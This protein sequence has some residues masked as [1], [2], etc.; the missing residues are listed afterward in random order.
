MNS[1]FRFSQTF[2]QGLVLISLFAIPQVSLFGQ[3]NAIRRAA[4]ESQSEAIRL[5]KVWDAENIRGSISLFIDASKKWEKLGDFKRSSFCLIESAK[6]Y[7]RVSED[8]KAE[9]ALYQALRLSR[10]INDLDGRAIELALLARI[11]QKRGI[12]KETHS[13]IAK[14]IRLGETASPKTRAYIFFIAGEYEIQNSNTTSA[15]NHLEK[16]KSLLSDTS[17]ANLEAEILRQLAAFRYANGEIVRGLT[18]L[19]RA[20]EIWEGSGNKRGIALAHNAFGFVYVISN[21]KQKAVESYKKARALFPE[22]VDL[23]EQ[24][25][26]MKGLGAVYISLGRPD[27]AKAYIS[28]SLKLSTENKNKVGRSQALNALVLA[29]YLEGNLD[30]AKSLGAE[31]KAFSRNTGNTFG[32]AF[33]DEILGKIEADEGN[34]DAAIKRFR[35]VQA[36]YDRSRSTIT[37]PLNELGKAYEAKGDFDL[38]QK[39]YKTALKKNRRYRDVVNLSENLYRL[40]H[41]NDK[42]GN[43]DPAIKYS[44]EAVAETESIYYDLDNSGLRTSFLSSVYDRYDLYISLLMKIHKRIPNK[45]YDLK[46]L[47]VS[48]RARA[49]L[50]LENLRLTESDFLADGDPKLIKLRR[51][52]LVLLNV[53]KTQLTN[54]VGNNESK[55]SAD[56]LLGEIKRLEAKFDDTNAVLRRD[57]P[58]YSELKNPTEFDI[59]RFQKDVLDEDSVLLEFSFGSEESYLWLIGKDKV[60]TFVLPEREI[61]EKELD[62]LLK[63]LTT[64]RNLYDDTIE[65]SQRRIK[66][67]EKEFEIRSAKLS[68]K[69]FGQ[70]ASKIKNKRLIIVPDGKLR[71]FPIVALPFPKSAENSRENP[72]F[73]ETNEIIYEPSAAMLQLIKTRQNTVITPEKDLLVVSDPVFTRDDER[74]PPAIRNVRYRSGAFRKRKFD[75]NLESLNARS[76]LERLPG[77]DEEANRIFQA[78]TKKH[79]RQLSGFS[80][81]RKNLLEEN[82]S[83]YKILHFATHGLLN[84][85]NPELSGILLSFY[86]E[87]ANK[88]D[89]FIRLQDIY[90]FHLSS[91]LVVLSACDTAVGKEVKGEGLMSLTNG[92]LQVGAKAVIS[93]RWKVDDNA[94]LQLMDNFYEFMANERLTPSQALSKAQIKMFRKSNYK[95]PFYWAAFSIHGDFQKRIDIRAPFAYRKYFLLLGI[96]LVLWGVIAGTRYFNRH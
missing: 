80:A 59:G 23:L 93:S 33:V 3:S 62:R 4:S 57:S 5:A 86:D 73:L 13:L 91:D 15:I 55:I 77:T 63:L 76:F 20:F 83:K 26:T 75:D 34:Y 6:L 41:L 45:G 61:L 16:A 32:L 95:S 49:R 36:V 54:L 89:G 46:A 1:T 43:L 48:E 29:E 14:S 96:L 30:R 88:L 7:G 21:Q 56:S 78:F 60:E 50:M 65:E 27:L 72:P 68:N 64:R 18:M 8:A 82:L 24:A 85:T 58:I 42:F 2:A 66:A 11:K 9:K 87:K 51:E 12:T 28:D 90:N 81:T 19:N 22:G 52:I 17:D 84:E 74:F 44:R 35:S 53:R 39:Y 94:S 79:S 69:L 25:A 67:A 92:F 40:S 47:Q 31:A 70:I 38:A 71:Y 37:T 10:K